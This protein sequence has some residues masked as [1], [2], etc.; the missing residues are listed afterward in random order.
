MS[1]TC[2]QCASTLEDDAAA[3]P[4]CGKSAAEPAPQNAPPA[5]GVPALFASSD[6]DA[7]HHLAGIGGWLILSAIGL[8]LSPLIYLFRLVMTFLPFFTNTRLQALLQ[9][10]QALHALIL[11][12]AIT[13]IILIAMLVWLIYMFFNRKRAFPTFMILFYVLACVIQSAD[14]FAAIVITQKSIS[15]LTLIRTLLAAA[16]WIPYYL[17]SRRVKVTFVH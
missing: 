2:P 8:V 9:T 4:Q 1:V 13:Q 5:Y 16:I 14:H 6:L 7:D 11:F 15:S 10:H 3:C 12:E 17:R